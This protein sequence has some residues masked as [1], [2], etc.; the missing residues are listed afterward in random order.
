MEFPVCPLDVTYCSATDCQNKVCT[1]HPR[2]LEALKDSSIMAGAAV[3]VADFSGTCGGHTMSARTLTE[4]P[5]TCG[6]CK[7][8]Y[9]TFPEMT[10]PPHPGDVR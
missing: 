10:A 8:F 7:H 1:R 5:G 4:K 6:G 9:D 2:V 3:S